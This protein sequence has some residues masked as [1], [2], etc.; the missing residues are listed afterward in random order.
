MAA[1]KRTLQRDVLK[2]TQAGKLDKA[3]EAYRAIIK[4][5]PKDPQVRNNLGDLLAKLGKKKDAIAEYQEGSALYE[6]DG[7]GPRAIALTQKA[8]RLDPEQP[9]VLLKLGDL[10]AAQK[11]RVE[12]RA[13]FV[14]LAERHEK[15]HEVAAALE[16][17]R[18]IADL[19]PENLP[20]RVKL[21]GMFEKQRLAEK[22][23]DEYVRAAKGYA[24]RKERDPAAQLLVRAFKLFP[25]NL[26]ARRLL[27]DVYAQRQE[28]SVVVGLLETPVARGVSDAA[29]TVLYADALTRVNHAREAAALLEKLQAADPNSVPVNLVLGRAYLK[30]GEVEKGGAALNR[31]VG[32]HIA[33]NRLDLAGTLLLELAAAAPEDDRVQQRIIE[34]AQKR[35]D[36]AAAADGYLRLAAIYEKKGLARNAVGALERF[37]ESRPG[38]AAASA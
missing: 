19:D 36:A 6:K 11:L 20:V 23:S 33:E 3:V 34:V 13:I 25:A 37:L 35:G 9:A 24:A 2:L 28:W 4:L 5:D 31:C 18:R 12:A 8:V 21:A 7:F 14:Q 29:M 10:Y 16:M 1:D 27:A 22:A 15:R 38:D 26:E 30:A 17:F 32:A